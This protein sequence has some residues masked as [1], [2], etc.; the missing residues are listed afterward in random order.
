MAGVTITCS[1]NSGVSRVR[2]Q[3]SIHL[4]G[5]PAVPIDTGYV[6]PIDGKWLTVGAAIPFECGSRNGCDGRTLTVSYTVTF[7]PERRRSGMGITYDPAW[8]L[9]VGWF[10]RTYTYTYS[11]SYVPRG[12]ELIPIR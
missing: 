1:P 4:A 11:M 7:Y 5:F 2:V 12:G 3:G 10:T 9:N 6:R 8:R